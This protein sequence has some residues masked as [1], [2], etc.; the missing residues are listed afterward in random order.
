MRLVPVNDTLEDGRRAFYDYDHMEDVIDVINTILAEKE[1]F[2]SIFMRIANQFLES[3]GSSIDKNELFDRCKKYGDVKVDLMKVWEYNTSL[4]YIESTMMDCFLKASP[5]LIRVNPSLIMV[6]LFSSF[7]GKV[8]FLYLLMSFFHE[9]CYLMTYH[10]N[11]LSGN[12]HGDK[13]RTPQKIGTIVKEDNSIVADCGVGLELALFGGLPMLYA[14]DWNRLCIFQIINV[15]SP[16]V[17]EN[18]KRLPIPHDKINVAYESILFWHKQRKGTLARL[19]NFCFLSSEFP[20]QTLETMHVDQLDPTSELP[21]PIDPTVQNLEAQD[22]VRF[23]CIVESQDQPRSMRMY[24][25]SILKPSPPHA[26][27]RI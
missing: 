13:Y 15:N 16:A 7:H 4:T 5:K 8:K 6:P 20:V 19:L 2:C 14:K 11:D 9:V 10:F 25:E 22:F 24:K 26:D 18:I 21:L 12:G 27:M 17:G 3:T 1:A 23:K